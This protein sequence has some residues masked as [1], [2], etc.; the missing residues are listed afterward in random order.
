VRHRT[1]PRAD[2]K[3]PQYTWSDAW[4]LYSIAAAGGDES[5]AKLTDIVSV[6]DAINHAI[7]TSAE[8][9]RG[10]GKLTAAKLVAERRKLFFLKGEAVTAWRRAIKHR[11][12]HKVLE[13]IE[14]FLGAA[15]YPAGDPAF[16]DPNWPYPSL[17]DARIKAAEA[18]YRRRVHQLLRR[19]HD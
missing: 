9:R 1:R 10:F 14:D 11:S 7:F 8:L 2:A 13:V 3:P 12:A 6:G 4:L 15:P 17:T 5:G 16:E 18:E 19:R